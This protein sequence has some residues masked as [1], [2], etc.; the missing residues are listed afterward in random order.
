MIDKSVEVEDCLKRFS[1]ERCLK[2]LVCFRANMEW[3]LKGRD[4]GG[5]RDYGKEYRNP[6][7]SNNFM[8][9]CVKKNPLHLRQ[10]LD[11]LVN[12]LNIQFKETL[13]LDD[14][15]LANCLR[16]HRSSSKMPKGKK[17]IPIKE[18]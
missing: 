15:D 18:K 13:I 14:R 2:N 16:W 12:K 7:L 1:S 8:S 4:L 5:N 17:V 3:L 11:L 10:E 6:S 9:P